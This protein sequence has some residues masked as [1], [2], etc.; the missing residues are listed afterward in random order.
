LIKIPSTGLNLHSGKAYGVF[1][2]KW[3]FVSCVVLFEVGSVLC[4]A[5]PNMTALIVGRVI[6]G[7]GG[8]G[9]YAGG[10]TYI[11]V[12][13]N[14]HERPLYL[15][16]IAVV[17]GVGS[18]IGPII[19]GAFAASSA[20]WRWAFYIN[21]VIAAVLAPAFYFCLPNV[22][23]MDLSITKK[24]RTQDWIGITIFSAGSACFTMAITFGGVVFPYNGGSE[25]ALWVMT[26]VLLILFV[27][28]TIFHPGVSAE[29]KLYPAH[30]VK[31]MELVILQYQLFLAS[32]SM[33]ITVYYTP[34]LFQFTR[35]DDPL[36]AGVRILPL[37]FMIVF[38]AIFNGA[39]MP[40]LGYHMP[41]YVFGNAMILI[42]SSLM[43]KYMF[44]QT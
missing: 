42:G 32:G 9:V 11:S 4:G 8:S 19:G 3:M 31:R 33:M 38:F 22:N 6:G 29:N 30:F 2:I 1:N 41:W 24:L 39:L 20:T 13:T 10:L 44:A 37:I 18:V 12:T 5:A 26:G 14:S 28:V 17:W 15:A 36:K 43:C 7:V 27:L 16:G 21:L 40:K 25:I 23:P 35:G 34:L